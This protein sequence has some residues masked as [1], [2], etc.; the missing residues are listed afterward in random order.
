MGSR[1]RCLLE[2]CSVRVP[3]RWRCYLTTIH[4][5]TLS[6]PISFS[7]W[8]VRDSPPRVRLFASKVAKCW[9]ANDPFGTFQGALNHWVCHWL[10]DVTLGERFIKIMCWQPSVSGNKDF[11]S[12]WNET[13][14]GD[15]KMQM[16]ECQIFSIKAAGYREMIE[17]KGKLEIRRF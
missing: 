3:L 12:K 11:Y 1:I 8:R 6:L 15:G 16:F 10:E 2:F 17:E 14:G 7:L 13:T 4:S 9:S 5:A